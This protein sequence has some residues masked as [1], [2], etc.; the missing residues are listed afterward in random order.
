MHPPPHGDSQTCRQTW[1]DIQWRRGQNHAPVTLKENYLHRPQSH[2]HP[3]GWAEFYSLVFRE[4]HTRR[5]RRPDLFTDRIVKTILLPM[6]CSTKGPSVPCHVPSCPHPELLRA[7]VR[8]SYLSRPLPFESNLHSRFLWPRNCTCLPRAGPV[9][10]KMNN[11]GK[12]ENIWTANAW[13]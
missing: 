4:I 5:K 3:L 11:R 10:G 1:P 9:E 8:C 7:N 12:T 13:V 2:D 6:M